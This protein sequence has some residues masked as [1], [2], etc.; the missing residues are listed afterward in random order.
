MDTGYYR[1]EDPY[2][3]ISQVAPYAVNWQIKESPFG[4]DSEVRT[5]LRKNSSPSSAWRV[6]E[7]T[8]RSRRS[9]PRART[10]IRS[11]AV[12]SFLRT[13]ARRW[14]PLLSVA[15]TGQGRAGHADESDHA[16]RADKEAAQQEQNWGCGARADAKTT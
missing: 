5:D 13:F 11:Q 15:P 14:T 16:A 7:A 4:A 10:T 12:P 1:S 9:P 2:A 3:D 8:C 6:I